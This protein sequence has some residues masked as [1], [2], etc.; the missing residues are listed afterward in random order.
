MCESEQSWATKQMEKADRL[1]ENKN[2]TVHIQ[3][4]DPAWHELEK[5]LENDT[6]IDVMSYKEIII[7]T[8]KWQNIFTKNYTISLHIWINLQQRKGEKGF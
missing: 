8:K 1:P 5:R 6:G 7:N 4:C 2:S 3:N